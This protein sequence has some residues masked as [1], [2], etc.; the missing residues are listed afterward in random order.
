MVLVAIDKNDCS[1]NT[2]KEWLKFD[3]LKDQS[4]CFHELSSI[5]YKYDAKHVGKMKSKIK[6]VFPFEGPLGI[7]LV[8]KKGNQGVMVKNILPSGLV[9][10]RKIRKTMSLRNKW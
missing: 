5:S 9:R 1:R 4:N 7:E 6:T 3:L 10:T 8:Q 2:L